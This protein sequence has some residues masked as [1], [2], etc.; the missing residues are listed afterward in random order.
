VLAELVGYQLVRGPRWMA[1]HDRH[2]ENRLA[3]FRQLLD[4]SEEQYQ[5]AQQQL[6]SDTYRLTKM[7]DLGIRLSSIVGSMH[8]SLIDFATPVLATSDHPVDVWPVGAT[9]RRPQGSPN[10]GVL[11]SLEIRVP[12]TPTKALLMTWL[13]QPD[14]ATPRLR[15][16]RHHAS[17]LNAFTVA[18]ATANGSTCPVEIRQL[19]REDAY[20]PSPLSC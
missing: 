19:R 2:V 15:G 5:A 20:C 18:N 4:L 10:D 14:E 6:T 17:H 12:L 7:L 1:W 9:T 8:W 13:V 11:N 3:E 16:A